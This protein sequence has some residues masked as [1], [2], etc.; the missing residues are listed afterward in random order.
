MA[1]CSSLTSH[2]ADSPGLE[3]QLAFPILRFPTLPLAAGETHPGAVQNISLL[4]PMHSARGC[5]RNRREAGPQQ[6]TFRQEHVAP[7]LQRLRS[8]PAAFQAQLEDLK[9]PKQSGP[10]TQ[11]GPTPL[12]V[13]YGQQRATSCEH[14]RSRGRRARVMARSFGHCS[15]V[16]R[17][18]PIRAGTWPTQLGWAV[19]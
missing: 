8:L 13:P 9:G 10:W 5:P 6:P 14:H 17:D 3:V 15:E 2:E 16:L 19:I 12:P 18:F 4:Q 1:P 7:V 11:K